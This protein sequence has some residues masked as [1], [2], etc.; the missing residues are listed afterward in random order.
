METVAGDAAEIEAA[1]AAL[2]A[3]RTRAKEAHEK[4]ETFAATSSFEQYQHLDVCLYR[5]GGFRR[6]GSGGASGNVSVRI[7]PPAAV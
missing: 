7:L 5:P 2:R 4:H 6:G 3:A 1:E